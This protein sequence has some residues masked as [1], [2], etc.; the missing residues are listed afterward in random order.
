MALGEGI[1][2]VVVVSGRQSRYEDEDLH[3]VLRRGIG[4]HRIADLE[5]SPRALKLFLPRAKH[6]TA[7][8]VDAGLVGR[9]NAVDQPALLPPTIILVEPRIPVNLTELTPPTLDLVGKIDLPLGSDFTQLKDLIL[10]AKR[11]SDRRKAI[12]ELQLVPVKL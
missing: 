9:L 10:E 5:P 12:R 6:V 4:V 8:L 1:I 7:L 11:R 2:N 3:D